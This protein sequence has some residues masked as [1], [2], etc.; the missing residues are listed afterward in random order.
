[1]SYEAEKWYWLRVDGLSSP[2]QMAVLNQLAR[3]V[4]KGG[5]ICFPKVELLAE[6]THMS[7]RQVRRELASLEERGLIH[8]YSNFSRNG[9]KHD[10]YVLNLQDVTGDRWHRQCEAQRPTVERQLAERASPG[11]RLASKPPAQ[12]T[13]EG[14]RV[15][16]TRPVM[17]DSQSY[18]VD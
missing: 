15:R 6:E 18:R 17:V 4:R 2:Y 12:L 8:R 1:M 9:Q 11:T 16:A 14:K 10:L 7:E 13:L 5:Q 3:H